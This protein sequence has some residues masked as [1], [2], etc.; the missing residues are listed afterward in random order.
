[1]VRCKVVLVTVSALAGLVIFRLFQLSRRAKEEESTQQVRAI[2]EE[3]ESQGVGE[4]ER[5]RN[6]GNGSQ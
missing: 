3:R 5:K 1:M 6:R 4:R 2:E